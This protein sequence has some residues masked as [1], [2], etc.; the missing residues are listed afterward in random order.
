MITC[1]IKCAMKLYS[2]PYCIGCTVKL[3][4]QNATDSPRCSHQM[5]TFSAI[6]ALCEGI[7]P[8]TGEFPSQHAQR[9]A[10]W[11]L[12]VFFDLCLNKWLSKQSR[13]RWFEMPSHPLWCQWF[14]NVDEGNYS[15]HTA[16]SF[17]QRFSINSHLTLWVLTR[18]QDKQLLPDSKVHGANM[19][20]TWVLSAPGGPHVALMN[21][22]LWAY[23]TWQS[24]KVNQP[25]ASYQG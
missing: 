14:Q 16:T 12:D 10:T 6:L 5:K 13:C 25:L 2:F 11:S 8:V 3:Y 21:L 4:F 23:L 15:Y 19:G 9:R 22:A 20:P 17:Y 7:S 1:S 24:G 18:K